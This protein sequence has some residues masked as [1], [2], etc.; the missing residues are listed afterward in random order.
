MEKKYY[1][2]EEMMDEDLGKIG[3]PGRDAFEAAVQEEIRAYHI[4]EA[5]RKARQERALTQEQLGEM[6]GVKKARISKIE[7]GHNITI[8][9][10]ARAFRAMGID[11]TL[12]LGGVQVAL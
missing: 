6:M 8:S 11:A 1:S 4:G 2:L 3:T 9:T 7:N 5:I 12:N 10:M